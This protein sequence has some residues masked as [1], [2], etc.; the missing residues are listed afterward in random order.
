MAALTLVSCNKEQV[1][2]PAVGEKTDENNGA[3]GVFS[4]SAARELTTR[5][6]LDEESNAFLWEDGESLAVCY[7]S[8]VKEFVYDAAS[9]AFICEDF[10][11][12]A[13]G[14]FYIVSPYSAELSIDSGRIRTV[15]PSIQTAGNKGCDPS[16]LISVAKADDVE[17]LK[18]GVTLKN[19][20]SLIKVTV[21]D[22]DVSSVSFE[23]NADGMNL[24]PVISGPVSI[25]PDDASVTVSGRKTAVTLTAASGNLE[26]GTYYIAAAPATL[27]KGIKAI[28]KRD[29]E[30]LASFRKTSSSRTLVRN[31]GLNL[32]SFDVASLEGRC[33]YIQNAEDMN[34]WRTDSVSGSDITFLGDD[35]DMGGAAHTPFD[36]DGSFDGQN[37]CIACFKSERSG[38][39]AAF[40]NNTYGDVSN[41]IFGSLDGETYDGVSI[42]TV[43]GSSEAWV[44][45]GT[46]ARLNSNATGIRTYVPVSI[47]SSCTCKVRVGGLFGGGFG[48]G[49]KVESCYNYAKVSSDA[50]EKTANYESLFGG[51]IGCC[52]PGESETIYFVDCH[53]YGEVISTDPFCTAVG[54]IVSNCPSK[55][56]AVITDCHN[57]ANVAINTVNAPT[58]NKDG[59][60]GGIG[61]LLNGG[62]VKGI[63]IKDCV[64]HS[65]I[66]VTGLT[67][68]NIGGIVGRANCGDIDGCVNEGNIA[69]NANVGSKAL[70]IG[71]I[72]GGMY[73]AP[74]SN[75][76]NCTNNGNISS[77]KNQVNRIGGIVGTVNSGTN[78]ISGCI[79]NG[80]VTLSRSAANS[81]WQA[82]GGIVGFQQ[83]STSCVIKK[84]ENRNAVTISMPNNFTSDNPDGGNAINA[85]GIVGLAVHN[86]DLSE[87]INTGDVTIDNTGS[88]DSYAGGIVGQFKDS[89]AGTKSASGDSSNCAVSVTAANAYAGALAGG[90][91]AKGTFTGEK[92]AGSVNGV[93]LST[94][95]FEG[96]LWGA[97]TGTVTGTVLS[98]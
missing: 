81:N 96:L 56:L 12:S 94:D 62:G 28:F 42:I 83:A 45:A 79:N 57:Y 91:A 98:K 80:T 43:D 24:A 40:F 61:G 14:P 20:F 8:T 95:N 30:E 97:N 64:N 1:E 22:S 34:K 71:G 26:A 31:A 6:Y 7:G 47:L 3:A 9:E 51:I 69:F 93:T 19:A 50:S 32:G 49:S 37:H 41:I 60:V 65:D 35:I 82:A 15:L 46:I 48:S 73:T 67:A 72:T 10:D 17:T 84:C 63:L 39:N 59:Y 18:E 68:A 90:N 5:T 29:G 4:F 87:N 70:L 85:G 23:G 55:N 11:E 16:A 36:I 54:G 86:I 76:T 92:V 27:E 58:N 25:D 2:S 66:E 53:N 13:D 44:Y 33:R 78:T 88:A 21:N 74:S 38:A 52:N 75:V 77:N 89:E